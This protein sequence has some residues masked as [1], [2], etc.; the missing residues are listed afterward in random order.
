MTTG[1]TNI[2]NK[3]FKPIKQKLLSFGH[4]WPR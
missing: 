1:E 2:Q 4:K 3:Q